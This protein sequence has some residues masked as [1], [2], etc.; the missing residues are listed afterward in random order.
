MVAAAAGQVLRRMLAVNTRVG[1]S[2]SRLF[3]AVSIPTVVFGSQRVE[4]NAS[5]PYAPYVNC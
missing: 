4:S 1:G 3:H 5:S 2:D